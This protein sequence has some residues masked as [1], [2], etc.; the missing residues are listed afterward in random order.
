VKKKKRKKQIDET[1]V[2]NVEPSVRNET[3]ESEKGN[4]PGFQRR[5][6]DPNTPQASKTSG[7][8]GKTER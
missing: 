1:G 4:E 2:T 5:K 7:R 8:E 6:K 3:K